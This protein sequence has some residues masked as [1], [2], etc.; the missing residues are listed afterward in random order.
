MDLKKLLHALRPHWRPLVGGILIGLAGAAL[1]TLLATPQYSSSTQVFVSTEGPTDTS[2][3]AAY[4]GTLL[5]TRRLMSYAELLDG[6]RVAARVIDELALDIDPEELSDRVTVLPVPQTVLLD[7]TVTDASPARARDIAHSLV[8]QFTAQVSELG[9]PDGTD[10]SAEVTMVE[11][12]ELESVAVGPHAPR[13]LLRGAEIGLLIGLALA[14]LRSRTDRS[15]RTGGDVRR[16]VPEGLIGTLP[17]DQRLHDG[18]LVMVGRKPSAGAEA[19]GAISASLQLVD[20]L[21]PPRIL[22]VSS[23]LP[24]EGRSTLAVNLAT[25]LAQDGNRV[26]LVEADLRRPRA[27]R[28]PALRKAS[29][30]SDV[31]VGTANLAGVVMPSRQHGLSVLAAG[32]LR[33]RPNEILRSPRMRTLLESLR[34]RY[35]R[36]VI[37]T[38]PLLPVAEAAVLAG[39]ADGC[40]LVSQYGRIRSDQ[41]AEAAARLERAGARVLGVVLNRAPGSAITRRAFEHGYPADPG[42]EPLRPGNVRV[43]S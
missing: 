10:A 34:E 30:L 8:R 28:P 16:A 13:N 6:E 21:D 12:P 14:Y 35:D 26:I 9:E 43:R 18:Q 32:H 19:I 2:P 37:D 20:P 22:A 11:P 17:E 7:I 38:P 3:V 15:V 40:L 29:G 39:L 1:V 27:A 24:G 33:V 5:S 25:A 36:V 23:A 4:Q 31:L 41:L 42:R